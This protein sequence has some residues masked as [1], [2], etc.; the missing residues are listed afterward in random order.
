MKFGESVAVDW[1]HVGVENDRNLRLAAD[2]AHAIEHAVNGRAGSERTRGCQLINDAVCERIRKWNAEFEDIDTSFLECE[3]QTARGGEIRIAGGDVS[4]QR[5]T[6]GSAQ[7]REF[8][9]ETIEH[10]AENEH[11]TSNIQYRTS[12]QSQSI[13]WW[14]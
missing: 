4:D 13:G 3:S 1:V 14:M 12:N 5:L 10:W 8:F 9:I 7:R 2:F 6:A 11:R